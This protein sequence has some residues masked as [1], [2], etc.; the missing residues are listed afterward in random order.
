MKFFCIIRMGGERRVIEEVISK[1]FISINILISA[2]LLSNIIYRKRESKHDSVL[3]FEPKI[4]FGIY[5]GVVGCLLIYYN[6]SHTG[7]TILDFGYIAQVLI[8]IHGG[9]ISLIIQGII[10]L[11]FRSIVYGF[12]IS[13]TVSIIIVIISCIIIFRLNISKFKQWIYISILIGSMYIIFIIRDI[14]VNHQSLN[15]LIIF[16]ISLLIVNYIGHITSQYVASTNVLYEMY[17]YEAYKDFLTGLNNVRN[18]DLLF[19]KFSKETVEK[20]QSLSLMMIDIDFFKRVNDT[21][22]HECGDLV[23]KELSSILVRTCREYD[24]VSR[25]GGEEFII[26]LPYTTSNQAVEVGERVRTVVEDYNFMIDSKRIIKITVSVGIATYPD[27]INDLTNL[28]QYA[29]KAL[30]NSKQTGRNKVSV[31]DKK[32]FKKFLEHKF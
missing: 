4:S 14:F 31:F 19:K 12:S 30:Y 21:Y 3:L 26:L 23:L 22:G 17:K 32:E 20:N 16:V 24:V 29:D 25:I 5:G 13:S 2:L 1:I 15:V 18:Y 9:W 27:T 28:K 8:G 6:F 7:D 10:M 11:I